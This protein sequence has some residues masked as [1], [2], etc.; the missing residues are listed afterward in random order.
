MDSWFGRIGDAEGH[1]EGPTGHVEDEATPQPDR[2]P[3]E[4]GGKAHKSR[5]IE[6]FNTRARSLARQSSRCQAAP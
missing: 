3:A 2:E 6:S 4:Q 5:G 1:L